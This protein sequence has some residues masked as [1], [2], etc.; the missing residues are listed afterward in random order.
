[1]PPSGDAA[2][3]F[4]ESITRKSRRVDG[5]EFGLSRHSETAREI[6]KGA[7]MHQDLRSLAAL[8][9]QGIA[10]IFR[11]NRRMLWGQAIALFGVACFGVF[12]LFMVRRKPQV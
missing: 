8:T 5:F 3:Y 4:D 7:L 10:R 1:V 2:R 9:L 12:T 6:D 11:A